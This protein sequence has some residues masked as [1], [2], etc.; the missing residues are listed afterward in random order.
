MKIT[1]LKSF[2]LLGAFICFGIAKAQTVS[3]TVSDASGPLPGAS[4]VVKG[5][6]NGTQT[7]FDG[8]Y[9]LNDVA[10][11]AVIV[12]S[13]IGF[14]SQE[15]SVSGQTT[16][17]VVLQEDASELDEVVVVGYGTQTRRTAVGAIESVKSEEFNKGVIVNPQQL[18]QGKSAGVQIS[19]SNGEPGAAVNV[20]IRGTASVRSNNNPLYVV[21]G[22]PLSGSATNARVGGGNADG[23]GGGNTDLGTSSA[24]DPLS[25]LNPNDIASIDILKDAAA[26]AIYGSRGANGVVLIT[27]KSGKSGKSVLEFSSTLSVGWVPNQLELL[28]RDQFLDA[29]NRLANILVPGST[30]PDAGFNT[31]T[32]DVIYK[33]SFTQNHNLSY[34][35]GNENGNY[36][37]SMG[38]QDQQGEVEDSEFDRLTLRINASQRFFDNKLRLTTQATISNIE[39]QRAPI[40]DGPNARGDLLSA[41]WNFAPDQ[42][43]TGSGSGDFVGGFYQPSAERRN[44][45]ALL[46]L[47][48]T[49]SSTLRALINVGAKYNFTDNLSFNTNVGLD[50]S[51]SS[52]Y[53]VQSRN[54]VSD[55][56]LNV[57][58]GF[59]NEQDLINTTW[60]SYFN[61]NKA[62]GDNVLDMTLGHSYQEFV[63]ETIFIRSAGFRT[64]N[65]FQ[66]VNN[67]ASSTA[68]TVDSTQDIDELQ[69]FFFRTN[70]SIKGKYNFSGT[71]RVD[72][73]SRFGGNN[74]YGTF[75][76]VG[77]AWTL[78]EEDWF[79]E[80]FD[81]FK[82]RT[83]WGVVGNQEGLGTNQFIR[84]DRFTIQN[85]NN[86]GVEE[87]RGLGNVAFNNADLKWEENTQFTVGIDYGFLDNRITGSLEYYNY[88]TDGFLLQQVSPQPALN[89][90]FFSNVDGEIKNS[91]VDFTINVIPIE[92]EDFTWDFNLNFNYNE[93]ILQ[94]YDGVAIDA[95]PIN[96]PG[97]TGAFSQRLANDQP[98]FSFF[99]QDW[100]GLSQ[101]TGVPETTGI[102]QFRLSNGEISS[103]GEQVFI[104]E[105]GLPDVTLG[106]TQNFKYKNWDMS[107]FFNGLFG[108][109]IYNNN[110][111]AYLTI[112]NLAQGRNATVEAASFIGTEN[113]LNIQEVSS[114]FI[115]DGSFL[116]L[117]NVSVGHNVQLPENSIFSSLRLFANAQNLFVI[118]DYSGQDP[119][120]SIPR[121]LNNVPSAGI[122]LTA[123][124][125]PTTISI[126]FNA[127][128]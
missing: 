56:T 78:S 17:N 98:L 47:T 43:L 74:K 48:R 21:D 113:P 22:V 82:L 107:L 128:F 10:G 28:N 111:N 24:I 126:G 112:G 54:F 1:L 66:M 125:R 101:D 120:V 13:Y 92:T 60:E 97:L 94:N 69:S 32:Q 121:V 110:R 35:G 89:P 34:G 90:F 61:F 67:I 2:L 70:Y 49:A 96:G 59:F 95:G 105:S 64:D 11:D 55:Q 116:R 27:T 118:T 117:Q 68:Q 30:F 100:V 108:Q 16:I 83:A 119:E 14:S 99:V 65:L 109:S 84:R 6:T 26:T 72:G 8:N 122:D 29:Q 103:V 3:G 76:S 20:R 123:F 115:E 79:P 7:D 19:A 81:T 4:V 15:V 46:E 36:R 37:I 41:A 33:T 85:I 18:I 53:Q 42:A 86:E 102:N 12:F 63:T 52:S 106:I 93:N 124:P 88:V 44:P 91:G 80:F 58:R 45:L 127:S 57:G 114:R 87:A 73:S 9:T 40:S 77:A 23:T 50:K 71:V 25:F 5:T 62:F 39:N 31:N 75:G 38:Y 104:G 51:V